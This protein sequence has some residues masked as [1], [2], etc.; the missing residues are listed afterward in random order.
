[1]SILAIKLLFWTL[2]SSLFL[3]YSVWKIYPP[4]P[5]KKNDFIPNFDLRGSYF[6]AVKSWQVCYDWITDD[7]Y[8]N[9]SE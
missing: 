9:E 7:Y 3:K 8:K 6:F 1:M 4:P 5:P 2:D